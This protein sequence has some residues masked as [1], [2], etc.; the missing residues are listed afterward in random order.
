MAE[1]RKRAQ[2]FTSEEKERLIRLLLEHVDTI[3]N[4]KTDG[5]T[6][7]SKCMAWTTITDTFNASGSIYR[8]R[9][10]LHYNY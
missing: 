5:A 1:K 6:N 3:L 9:N 4:K 2:N 8:Y 7:E 10:L